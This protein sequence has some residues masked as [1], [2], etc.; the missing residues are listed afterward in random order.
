MEDCN[1][2]NKADEF[3]RVWEAINKGET[4]SDKLSEIVNVIST[5]QDRNIWIT[6]QIKTTQDSQG[7]SAEKHQLAMTLANE[8]NQERM[9]AQFKEIADK[10]AKEEDELVKAKAKREEDERIER[11]ALRKERK[12]QNRNTVILI[13]SFLLN[14]LMGIMVKYAPKLIGLG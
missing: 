8:K 5:N 13:V 10:K 11:I 7:V 3:K 14:L 1:D 6:E 12:T 4:K 2:C 9:M